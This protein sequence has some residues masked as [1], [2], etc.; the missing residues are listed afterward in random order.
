[1]N[2]HRNFV[3]ALCIGLTLIGCDDASDESPTIEVDAAMETGGTMEAGGTMG[4]GGADEIGIPSPDCTALCTAIDTLCD[5]ALEFLLPDGC[6]ADC[7]ASNITE[8]SRELLCFAEAL[9]EGNSCDAAAIRACIEG[10]IPCT[11]PEQCII[12]VP[13]DENFICGAVCE[14]GLCIGACGFDGEPNIP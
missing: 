10:I 8:D 13:S 6:P 9:L 14:D 1:V 4:M 2:H 7:P 5:P 3:L 11:G 12:P